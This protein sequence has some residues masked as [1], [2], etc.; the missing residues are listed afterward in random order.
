MI[1]NIKRLS[2]P[3]AA[4][5]V[6]ADLIT[7]HAAMIG[8]MVISTV[9]QAMNSDGSQAQ[10][11]ARDCQLYY[12]KFLWFLAPLF[13]ATFA[14]FGFYTHSRAYSGRFKSIVIGEG[15][16]VAIAMF[17]AVSFLAFPHEPVARGVA[18]PF[19]VLVAVGVA[20]IRIGK[21][22]FERRFEL[23]PRTEVVRFAAKAPRVLVMGGAGYIGS[24][25]VHRLLARGVS[26]RVLDAMVYGAGALDD[27]MKERSLEV[28]VGDCR[29]LGNVVAA[30][31][32][33]SA[34]VDLAAIV[35]DPACNE[36]QQAALEIN[37]AATRMIIEIAKAQRVRRFVFASTCSVYGETEFEVDE[38]GQIRPL[39]LY[40]QTKAQSEIALLA[41]A[42]EGFNPTIL[43]LATVFGLGYRPRFD[44]VV[45][46]LCARAYFDRVIT[47]YNSAQWRPFI[48]VGDAA[49]AILTTL[50]A[51]I[52]LVGGE[53]FNVGDRRLNVTLRQLAEKIGRAFPKTRIDYV[54][55]SDRRNYRVSFEK[56]KAW[57]NFRPV[58]DIDYG[59]EELKRA[60][61]DGRISNYTDSRYHNHRF[62]RVSPAPSDSDLD[63]RV[64]V[65]FG[66]TIPQFTAAGGAK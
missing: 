38:R 4:L 48:H 15:L 63:S 11:L 57:A 55:N 9:Y 3:E 35:G 43:R 16:G 31:R 17:L 39:S 36:D 37:Y 45:N 54:E 20:I 30:M 52:E 12:V 46:L 2:L 8:A 18:L 28:S 19:A 49:E 50:G 40:A 64:M 59:I 33:V 21:T 22:V 42:T 47:I 25:L 26:V 6:L 5:R 44:L 53:I 32:G 34:V 10:Q 41:A 1:P 62:L 27:V 65:A 7:V 29:N 51:P 23:H 58:R 66:G 61:T 60:F 24:E 14:A 56:I 13:P